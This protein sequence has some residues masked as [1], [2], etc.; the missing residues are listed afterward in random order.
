MSVASALLQPCTMHIY[1]HRIVAKANE[2]VDLSPTCFCWPK[3]FVGILTYEDER[4]YLFVSSCV[5]N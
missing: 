3:S 5:V 2:V 4:V 1:A